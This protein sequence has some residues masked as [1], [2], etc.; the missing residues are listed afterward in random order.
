MKYFV[1]LF[2]MLSSSLLRTQV[3]EIVYD[4]ETQS[5][6]HQGPLKVKKGDMI[7]LKIENLNTYLFDVQSSAT[8]NRLGLQTATG[9]I[10]AC[11][12]SSFSSTSL[13][14][15]LP[16]LDL[17]FKGLLSNTEYSIEGGWKGEGEEAD[18]QLMAALAIISR[19][20]QDLRNLETEIGKSFE[21]L[22]KISTY[23]TMVM[24]VKEE[25]RFLKGLPKVSSIKE[26]ADQLSKTVFGTAISDVELN[27]LLNYGDVPLQIEASLEDLRKIRQRFDYFLEKADTTARKISRN[28]DSPKVQR[29]IEDLLSRS[30]ASREN[31]EA[32]L[33]AFQK[34]PDNYRAPALKDLI[35]I[36]DELR[37]IN[38][39]SFQYSNSFVADGD[40]MT[41]QIQVSSDSLKTGNGSFELAPLRIP[42]YGGLKIN[43]S[44]GLAL[45]QFFEPGEVY[46][47]RDSSIYAS[48]GD[49]FIPSIGT[50]VHFYP[51]QASDL[52]I[53]GTLG[54]GFPISG[55]AT[56]EYSP[57]FFLGPS[58]LI[59]RAERLVISMG[60]QGGKVR[61][62][63]RGLEVGDAFDA[64]EGAIPTESVYELGYF[65]GL[66]FNVG[67]R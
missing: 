59:G 42:V 4:M 14:S 19:S 65:L 57:S 48:E 21:S 55:S 62:L 12:S 41:I 23:K 47:I 54:M 40:E 28:I 37:N 11:I 24:L 18:E 43:A 27:Q 39:G 64:G 6:R 49:R 32:K 7:H 16:G 22:R 46:G 66:S 3:L 25:I 60:L 13:P 58:L 10:F 35:R 17:W 61:R 45:G 9:P 5:Y 1:L 53:G 63:G 44:I 30:N 34:N 52:A 15:A 8:P 20:A 36:R 67:G 56:I 50:F 51:R 26:R 31:L 29:D 33:L 2:F 38:N